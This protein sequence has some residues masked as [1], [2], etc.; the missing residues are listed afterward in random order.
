MQRL[1][2][3]RR[4]IGSAEDLYSIVKTMKALSAV[5]INIYEKAVHSINKYFKNI[6]TGLQILLKNNPE[7][8]RRPLEIREESI[9]VIIFGAQK[10]LAGS[11]NLTIVERVREWINKI[12]IDKESSLYIC[13]TGERIAEQMKDIEPLSEDHTSLPFFH[14]NSDR[15]VQDI[16]LKIEEWRFEKNVSKIQ[17]FYNKPSRGNSFHPYTVQL[18]PL[19]MEWLKKLEKKK[20]PGRCIPLYTLE[21]EKLFNLLIRQYFYISLYRSFIESVAS[22]NASRLMTMQKAEQN[23]EERLNDLNIQYNQ[24]RQKAITDELLDIVAGFEALSK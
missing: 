5:N 22:E 13:S 7:I 10:G 16:L 3:I 21:T 6:E 19:D 9:G 23:I 2:S 15:V 1:E 20:W 17:L 12:N 8:L 4:Q 24:Q 18:F 11:F 14:N